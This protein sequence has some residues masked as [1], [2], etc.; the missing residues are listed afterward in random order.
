M[1]TPGRDAANKP[2]PMAPD[3][4]LRSDRIRAENQVGPH[5][6][7]PL[8][9]WDVRGGGRCRACYLP[10]SAHPIH[11]YVPSRPLGRFDPSAGRES[12][13]GQLCR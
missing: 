4:R 9:P 2:L 7:R 11:C 5:R 10:K 1:T 8:R 6:F 13:T 3:P 12:R